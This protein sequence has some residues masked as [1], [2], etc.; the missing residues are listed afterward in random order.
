M[1]V[2]A[3]A[4]A[5]VAAFILSSVYYALA[6]KLPTAQGTVRE[7]RPRPRQVVT[8]L[9]RSALV[10][11]LVAGLLITAGW[12]GALAGVLF[13]LALATIPVVLL[14]GSVIWEGVPV[15]VGLL[16]T[17]DWLLKLPLIGLVVGLF[18]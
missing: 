10:A 17:V 12:S 6:P 15:K 9:V 11:G 1:I 7:T 5:T 13:G 18:V 14:S 4:V 16:H 3:I 2:L 8:E